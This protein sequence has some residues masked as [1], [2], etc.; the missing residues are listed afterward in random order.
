MI[1]PIVS[2]IARPDH[3]KTTIIEKLIPEL[4][5]RGFKIGTIKHHVHHFEMDKP[6]K[7]T[8]RHKQAG[9][10]TVALSSP[11]GVGIIRDVTSD[12][13]VEEHVTHYFA[14]MDLVITEGY[15]TGPMPKI[16]VF[17]KEV[18]ASPLDN[19]DTTWVAFVTDATLDSDLPQ[20]SCGDISG[21]ASFLVDSFIT[22][23]TRQKTQL[24]VDGKI[25]PLNNFAESF[26]RQSVLGM[27][28]S[29]RGCEK[30]KKLTLTIDNE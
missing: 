4:V 24:L 26:L 1:P 19:R 22:N 20:F 16:E 13:S 18:S 25:I 6:G 3:G 5:G 17:R 12:S 21:L 7:D 28:S 30:P 23:N 11:T 2:F 14:G 27:V 10:H 29:L 9:A 15:K 8:W